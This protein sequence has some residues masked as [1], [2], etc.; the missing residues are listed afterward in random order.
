MSNDKTDGEFEVVVP[1]LEIEKH[2]Q[3]CCIRE[4]KR[5]WSC[6]FIGMELEFGVRKLKVYDDLGGWSDGGVCC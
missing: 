3:G 6:Q 1:Y 4:R 2:S 5:H